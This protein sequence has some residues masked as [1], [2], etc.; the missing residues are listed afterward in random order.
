LLAFRD[1]MRQD[2]TKNE[3][4]TSPEVYAEK[5]KLARDVASVLRKNVIQAVKDDARDLWSM[6]IYLLFSSH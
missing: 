3:S 1:T 4:L 2:S 5:V 6:L